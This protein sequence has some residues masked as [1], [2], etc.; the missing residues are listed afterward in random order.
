MLKY[1][2]IVFISFLFSFSHLSAQK[3]SGR[4][5]V[6]TQIVGRDT[7]PVLILKPYEAGGKRD[8]DAM[9]KF[10]EMNRMMVNVKYALPY[11]RLAKQ[12]LDQIES[13]MDT[14]KNEKEKK[15]YIKELEKKMKK[16]FQDEILNMDYDQGRMLIKLIYRET[17]RTSYALIKEVRGSLNA[18]LWQT[19]AR[20]FGNNLK[21][22]Y[23]SLKEDKQIEQ[24]IRNL[25]NQNTPQNNDN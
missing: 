17:G 11:A 8:P 2:L 4:I 6:N 9:K 1:T 3:D 7:L 23:D 21:S 16:Q 24:I 18:V 12:T 19:V 13:A 14:M 10:N 20:L 15:I 22:T 25:E 5:V